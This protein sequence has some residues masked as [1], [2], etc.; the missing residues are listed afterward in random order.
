MRVYSTIQ[1]STQFVLFNSHSARVE[2]ERK[3]LT[4]STSNISLFV[5]YPLP[6]TL[7]PRA[8]SLLCFTRNPDIIV[9]RLEMERVIAR[10]IGVMA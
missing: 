5:A 1:C 6:L 8:S 9:K 3:L 7:T 4:R 10:P 2:M